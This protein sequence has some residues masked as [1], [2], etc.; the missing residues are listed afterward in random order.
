MSAE[1]SSGHLSAFIERC[2]DPLP[3]ECL[4][5]IQY[6]NMVRRERWE[7]WWEADRKRRYFEA[8]RD[9]ADFYRLHIR[10]YQ[11][12][13]L[14]ISC[15]DNYLKEWRKALAEQ[16]LTPAACTADLAWK[17]RELGKLNQW[18]PVSSEDVEAAIAADEAFFAAHP[19]RKA[20]A[21]RKD[22]A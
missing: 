13:N 9:L 3:D 21:V 20:K 11:D 22:A 16:L 17:K 10:P 4:V 1:V 5:D 8:M 14:K 6:N 18:V 7:P 15:L 12:M 19:T 2:L